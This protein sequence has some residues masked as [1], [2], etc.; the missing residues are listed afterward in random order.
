MFDWPEQSQTSP[1]STS[2]AAARPDALVAVRVKGP[3]AAMAG[4]VDVPGAGAVGGRR[5]SGGAERDIDLLAG[6]GRP[7]HRDRPPALEHAMIGE[8]RIERRRPL[9]GPC[10]EEQGG[11][12]PAHH[13]RD[14]SHGCTGDVGAEGEEVARLGLARQRALAQPLVRG[15]RIDGAQIGAAEGELGDVGDREAHALQQ[16]AVR[17]IAARLPARVKAGPQTAF[18][19]DVGPSG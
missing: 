13:E 14:R 2:F 8:E 9:R 19:I 18:R 5:G 16:A 3:P 4:R 7:P 1:T 10:D 12:E 17:R 11:R 15:G 6:R